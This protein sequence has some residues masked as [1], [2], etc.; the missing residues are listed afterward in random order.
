MNTQSNNLVV[1]YVP[2]A[3]IFFILLLIWYNNVGTS[4]YLLCN[5]IINTNTKNGIFIFTLFK[6]SYNYVG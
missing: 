4:R 3:C 6:D 5:Q 1:R 2:V